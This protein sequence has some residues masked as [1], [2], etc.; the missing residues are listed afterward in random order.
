MRSKEEAHDYR[1]FPE[2]DLTPITVEKSV[3][4]EIRSGLPELPDAK[5]KRFVAGYGLPEYD[6]ELLTTEKA[7]AAWF[8]EAV[9]A[10]GQPKA[11]A[12]WVMGEL[13]KM[14]NEENTA[15]DSC[16]IKP[17]QLA[18]MLTLIGKGTISGKIAKTV[19]MEMY[20][21][22]KDAESIVK[23]KGLLQISDESA[24]EKAVDEIIA[25]H[26]A[27]VERFKAG[28]E[29]L[30]GFFVGQVMKTTKGKANP[31]MLNDLM[32]KKLS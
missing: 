31:Q 23:E 8:E 25:K 1:Y 17:K 29:K 12:N 2:P 6:A 22:G 24:I 28:E 16:P 14:L 15:I 20:K 5:R 7:V 11:V 19:F 18:D 27:E 4:D 26:P 10:G 30:L 9:Q 13:M 21:T 32:K 3:I